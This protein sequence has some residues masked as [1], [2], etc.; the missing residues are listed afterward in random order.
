MK[1]SIGINMER[2]SPS[3]SMQSEIAYALDRVKMA[4]G[5]G[6][7]IAWAAE[8]HCINLTIGPNPFNILT[9]WA[10]NTSRIRLGTAVLVAPYWH[11]IRLASEAALTDHYSEGRLEVGLGR[12]AF[13]YEFDRM[14]D[15]M[16]HVQ[17]GQY[18]REMVPL[19]KK[20]W[21]ADCAHDGKFWK[22]PLSTSVP[23]PTQVPF[24]P[25]WI[26][27]RNPDSFN[28]AVLEETDILSAPLFK[29]FQEVRNL[30]N[31]LETA[32][33]NNPSKPRPR[34]TVLRQT[35]VYEKKEDW[36]AIA[37]YALSHGRRFEGLFSTRG[38]VE[39]GFPQAVDIDKGETGRLTL[40]DIGEG[41]LHGTPEE[42]IEQ[43][44]QYR[45][46]GVDFFMYNADFG[47]PKP[48]GYRSLELFIERVI[49]YF[50]SNA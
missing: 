46:I 3:D 10:A 1:F 35:V 4:D 8:H 38:V 34:W 23:R 40:G 11:P 33:R 18:L 48:I 49:P 22:F 6:F 5:G 44:K 14:G 12:G 19:V 31:K 43:L 15:G 32:C 16:P 26:S 39:N 42:V 47:L 21:Q 20:L 25:L 13:Q 24:P 50:S 2:V 36:N 45:D 41:T 29:P 9:H 37:D 28:F 17:G 30:A 7:D 27:A